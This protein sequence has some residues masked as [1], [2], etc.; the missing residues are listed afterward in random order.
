M[1]FHSSFPAARPVGGCQPTGCL[2]GCL[3]MPHFAAWAA[4][5]GRGVGDAIIVHARDRVFA[6]SPAFLERGLVPGVPLGRARMLF[7]RARFLPRDLPAEQLGADRPRI[8]LTPRLARLEDPRL[9]GFWAAL[10]GFA[11]AELTRLLQQLLAQGGCAP[12]QSHAMLAALY[13]PAGRLYSLST[14]AAFFQ[15]APIQRLAEVGICPRTLQLLGWVGVRTLAEARRL[16]RQQLEAQFGAE[17][18]RLFAWL[19]P[20]SQPTRVPPYTPRSVTV[21]QVLEWTPQATL[22]LHAGL[23]ALLEA[24]S[25]QI[26]TGAAPTWVRLVVRQRG[27]AAQERCRALK[28]PFAGAAIPPG[29]AHHLLDQALTALPDPAP[30]TRLALTAGGLVRAQP[31]QEARFRTRPHWASVRQ[32]LGRRLPQRLFQ[33]TRTSAAPFLPEEE[34]A[35]GALAE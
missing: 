8:Q 31:V 15:A 9:H 13:A 7:P 29:P 6:A 17:G 35:L 19:H 11:P 23:A 26:P 3:Y 32:H 33:P 1:A 18:T 20:S 22:E 10:E 2:V 12:L 30:V 34:F 28:P 16:T 25:G 5:A 21:E 27:G 24:A 4:G 14:T